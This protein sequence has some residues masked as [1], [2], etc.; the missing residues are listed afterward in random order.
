MNGMSLK[1]VKDIK[2]N[3]KYDGENLQSVDK[4]KPGKCFE[5]PHP[6]V[7]WLEEYGCNARIKKLKEKLTI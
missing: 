7:E 3:L 6:W 1:K 2:V 5:L 4:T